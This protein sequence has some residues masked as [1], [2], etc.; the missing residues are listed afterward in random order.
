MAATSSETGCA[1]P[2]SSFVTQ[3]GC[4]HRIKGRAMRISQGKAASLHLERRACGSTANISR[5]QSTRQVETSALR[6]TDSSRVQ[7]PQVAAQQLTLMCHA[8]RAL[9]ALRGTDFAGQQFARRH[10]M[11]RAQFTGCIPSNPVRAGRDERTDF[12]SSSS[13]SYIYIHIYNSVRRAISTLGAV[14]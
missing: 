8:Y 11:Q 4:R 3:S 6:V 7:Q 5:S 12:A 2:W 9:C 1:A 10:P 13:P 14:R